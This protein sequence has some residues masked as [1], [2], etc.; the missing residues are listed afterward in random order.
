MPKRILRLAA[1]VVTLVACGLFM[2]LSSPSNEFDGKPLFGEV[3][4]YN[5]PWREVVIIEQEDRINKKPKNTL[6]PA[7][8]WQATP[9]GI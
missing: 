3:K 6:A 8:M 2:W 7:P 9:G 1:L 4:T 5:G